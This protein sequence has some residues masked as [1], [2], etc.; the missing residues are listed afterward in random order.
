MATIG[1]HYILTALGGAKAKGIDTKA[2]LKKA[3]IP[4]KPLKNPKARFHVDL[5]ARLYAD[6][7]PG[8]QTLCR[9]CSSLKR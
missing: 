8:S 5:V 4:E 6:I 7:G 2:L 3:R 9:Y 1:T